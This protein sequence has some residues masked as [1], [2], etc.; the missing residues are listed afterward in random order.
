MQSVF[1]PVSCFLVLQRHECWR[2]EA[3]NHPSPSDSFQW[4]KHLRIQTLWGNIISS[5]ADQIKVPDHC[6]SLWQ[7][8]ENV[9]CRNPDCTSAC[10]RISQNLHLQNADEAPLPF[11]AG[12]FWG[13]RSDPWPPSHYQNKNLLPFLLPLFQCWLRGNWMHSTG[14]LFFPDL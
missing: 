3:L 7:F 9:S 4:W 2:S 1:S 6:H 10:L 14:T 5:G 13:A 12:Y 11:Q 8:S